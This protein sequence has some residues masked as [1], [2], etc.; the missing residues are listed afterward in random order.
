MNV[1]DIK[2]YW[3][4]L[5][6]VAGDETIQAV[7]IEKP[8]E[9]ETSDWSQ[10]IPEDRCGVLLEATEASKLLAYDYDDGYGGRDCHALYAYTPTRVIFLT[11]YD[12]STRLSSVPRHPDPNERV[13]VP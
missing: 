11:E 7:L 8:D 6:W 9:W 5:A 12:G 3:D 10:R 1:C 13:Q 2:T 4:E